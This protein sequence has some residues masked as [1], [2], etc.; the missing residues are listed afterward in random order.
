MSSNYRLFFVSFREIM[1]CLSKK[2]NVSRDCLAIRPKNF[3][4]VIATSHAELCVPWHEPPTVFVGHFFSPKT[5]VP[6]LKIRSMNLKTSMDSLS[7]LKHLFNEW[8]I[9]FL[10]KII[11]KIHVQLHS[12]RKG[13]DHYYWNIWKPSVILWSTIHQNPCLS[14]T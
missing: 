7:Q 6:N 4:L 12:V 8:P 3:V 9:H 11:C 14:S 13:C 5:L 10:A 2:I 1:R